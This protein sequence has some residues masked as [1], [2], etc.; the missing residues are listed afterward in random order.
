MKFVTREVDGT[1]IA[2]VDLPNVEFFDVSS[3]LELKTNNDVSNSIIKMLMNNVDMVAIDVNIG[4]EFSIGFY[5]ESG[6]SLFT[7]IEV[8][9]ETK[10]TFFK[11]TGGEEDTYQKESIEELIKLLILPM[12]DFEDVKEKETVFTKEQIKT[13]FGL[14]GLEK[15]ERFIAEEA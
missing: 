12:L 9:E 6:V 13:M 15:L 14:D 4:G 8:T 2:K 5:N 1:C 3:Y 10:E 7:M 11:F